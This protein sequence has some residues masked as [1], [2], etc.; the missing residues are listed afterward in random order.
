MQDILYLAVIT[1][2]FLAAGYYAHF[3]G[4]I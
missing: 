2:F 1:G 4:R 3:C